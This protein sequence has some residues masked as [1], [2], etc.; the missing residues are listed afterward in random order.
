MNRIDGIPIWSSSPPSSVRAK[1]P[2][3]DGKDVPFADF[4]RALFRFFLSGGFLLRD[5]RLCFLLSR[6]FVSRWADCGARWPGFGVGVTRPF[7]LPFKS[8]PP[9][10]T[11][12]S[13]RTIFGV[14]GAFFRTTVS[15]SVRLLWF[16]RSWASSGGRVSFPG[17]ISTT[18]PFRDFWLRLRRRDRYR[19]GGDD[20]GWIHLSV[21]RR[22]ALG[23]STAT[24]TG[25]AWSCSSSDSARWPSVGMILERP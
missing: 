19:Y 20:L 1:R 21:E 17:R 16:A 9:E 23:L 8:F 5:V 24:G 12:R 6:V 25:S 18:W 4:F 14:G 2:S 11:W 13:A 3:P 10:M 22:G 15:F 7:L